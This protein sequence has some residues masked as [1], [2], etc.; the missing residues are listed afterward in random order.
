[1]QRRYDFI[2]IAAPLSFVQ[3][4]AM[5]II[6]GPDVVLC[7]RIARTKT[8]EFAAAAESLRGINMHIH[9]LVLWDEELPRI[10][11]AEVRSEKVSAQAN[12]SF[13]GESS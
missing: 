6:P 4:D 10:E 12:L 3:R 7:G 8:Q 9:G 2:V 5:S 1:M 13:A 11:T